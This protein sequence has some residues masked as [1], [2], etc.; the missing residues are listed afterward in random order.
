MTTKK[1]SYLQAYKEMRDFWTAMKN[2]SR[3][4]AWDGKVYNKRFPKFMEESFEAPQHYT[5]TTQVRAWKE[6][7]Q[8]LLILE[9]PMA[10]YTT[11]SLYTMHGNDLGCLGFLDESGK[12]IDIASVKKAIQ[13]KIDDLDK[14]IEILEAFDEEEAT[15]KCEDLRNAIF[16]FNHRLPYE[17]VELRV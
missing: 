6:I 13:K 4:D 5:F 17:F 1:E 16:W 11:V 15:K 9:G 10:R 3:L 12:C 14:R 7:K 2:D 8:V